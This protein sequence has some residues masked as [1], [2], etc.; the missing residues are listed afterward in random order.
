VFSLSKTKE[1]KDNRLLISSLFL[2]YFWNLFF[3]SKAVL[4][5]NLF[6]LTLLL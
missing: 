6:F 4:Y 3:C 2:R 1:D 5:I